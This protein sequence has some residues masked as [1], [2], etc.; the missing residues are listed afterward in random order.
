MNHVRAEET[1]LPERAARIRVSMIPRLFPSRTAEER[2]RA[3]TRF[4]RSRFVFRPSGGSVPRNSSA[5]SVIQ[6]RRE[7]TALSIFV[8]F[9]LSS[10]ASPAFDALH[11]EISM[12][13]VLNDSR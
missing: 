13:D 6:E 12:A 2:R 5:R 8:R 11:H 1:R 9:Y 7:G 10:N 4:R 3:E